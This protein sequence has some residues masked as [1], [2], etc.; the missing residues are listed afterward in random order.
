MSL[1]SHFTRIELPGKLRQGVPVPLTPQTEEAL[2]LLCNKREEWAVKKNNIFLFARPGHN[3]YIRGSDWIRKYSVECGAKNAAALHST[4]LRKQIATLS[5]V[6]NL[7]NANWDQLA[8]YLGHN[9]RIHEDFY[10]LKL[11]T[12]QIAKVSK[13][14]VAMQQGRIGDYICEIDISP[15]GM[16]TAMLSMTQFFFIIIIRLSKEC[17]TL[18]MF[19]NTV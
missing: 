14:L 10:R 7:K 18:C 11:D 6:L 5:S 19:T 4:E 13:L 16:H 12:L 8:R 2:E 3:T 17:A 9:I 1:F 15:D